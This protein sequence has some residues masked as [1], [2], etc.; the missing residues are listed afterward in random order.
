MDAVRDPSEAMKR[1]VFD[2]LKLR[3]LKVRQRLRKGSLS[4]RRE[5][6]IL[7]TL[8]FAVALLRMMRKRV[9]GAN[10]DLRRVSVLVSSS[11][12]SLVLRRLRLV[13]RFL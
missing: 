2:E 10:A 7:L 8:A 3:F 4:L 12:R 13:F 6:G 11:L 1:K 5:R 9:G